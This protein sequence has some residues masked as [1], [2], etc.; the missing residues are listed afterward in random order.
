[1]ALSSTSLKENKKKI[2]SFHRSID[3]EEIQFKRIIITI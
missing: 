1:M 3:N 2:K